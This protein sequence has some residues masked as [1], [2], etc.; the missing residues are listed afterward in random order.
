METGEGQLIEQTHSEEPWLKARK[1]MGDSMK[2]NQT[3][4][5]ADMRRFYALQEARGAS[6]PARS[7]LDGT[8]PIALQTETFEKNIDRWSGALELLAER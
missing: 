4:S 8:F 2:S 3:I 5:R 7:D 1:G 6:S